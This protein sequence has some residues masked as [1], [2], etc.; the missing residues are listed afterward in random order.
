VAEKLDLKIVVSVEE[1][2]ISNTIGKKALV[3]PC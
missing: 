1:L 3:N 2:L